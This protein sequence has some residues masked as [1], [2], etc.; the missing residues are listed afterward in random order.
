MFLSSCI[1][2]SNGKLLLEFFM[3]I[4]YLNF[5]STWSGICVMLHS[6]PSCS[7]LLHR[8]HHHHEWRISFKINLSWNLIK[9][10]QNPMLKSP[11]DLPPCY[12]LKSTQHSLV[13]CTIQFDQDPEYVKQIVLWVQNFSA[14]F[15][16]H[17]YFTTRRAILFYFISFSF[18]FHICT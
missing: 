14:C 13:M 11:F 4:I 3:M 7:A 15:C 9:K 18:V 16:A 1:L 12:H 10:F 17:F 2:V 5:C 6:L 8:F